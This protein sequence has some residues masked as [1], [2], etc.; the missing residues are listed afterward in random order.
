MVEGWMQSASCHWYPL[1]LCCEAEGGLGALADHAVFPGS[2]RVLKGLRQ[3][4][5]RGEPC[6]APGIVALA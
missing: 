4:R 3:S 5:A 6:A 2:S 1:R